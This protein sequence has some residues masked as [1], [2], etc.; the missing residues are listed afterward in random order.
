MPVAPPLSLSPSFPPFLSLSSSL[1][2]S[3]CLCLGLGL[4]R[5]L[6]PS[7]SLSPSVCPVHIDLILCH[8]ST[9]ATDGGTNNGGLPQRSLRK[10]TPD[11]VRI[12]RKL[13][14]VQ[15]DGRT[16]KVYM[17][18]TTSASFPSFRSTAHPRQSH[19]PHRTIKGQGSLRKQSPC[20]LPTRTAPG[21]HV[22]YLHGRFVVLSVVVDPAAASIFK[23]Y[24][25]RLV[26]EAHPAETA[27]AQHRLLKPTHHTPTQ[28]ICAC[29]SIKLR[30]TMCRIAYRVY[31]VCGDTLKDQISYCSLAHDRSS[32]SPCPNAIKVE[33]NV[34]GSCGQPNCTQNR[35]SKR[36]GN[37][38]RGTSGRY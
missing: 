7:P 9:S 25:P 30:I 6:A 36:W 28:L 11:V 10:M 24:I 2:L 18:G 31:T 26:V 32:R 29:S 13:D 27:P 19:H 5:G 21:F 14:G 37:A 34:N 20:S 22:I 33:M 38:S 17:N 15:S 12:G 16:P 4:G 8:F 35:T 1:S 23:I 3:V